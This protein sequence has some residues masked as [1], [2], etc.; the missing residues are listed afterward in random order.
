MATVSSPEFWNEL[1]AQGGDGWELGEP[2]LPLADF[3]ETTP[4][5]RGRVAVP[6]CGRGHDAR[7]L[8]RR[9]Y[10]VVGFDFADTAITEARTLTR[11]ER[12]DA[13]FEQRDIF[14]LSLDHANTFDGVWEYTCFCAI[15]PRRRE[16]YVRVMAAIL[17]P[18]G[19][20]LGCFYPIR[21]GGG[22]PPFPVSKREVRNL[23][24]P[25]FRIEREFSPIHSV[26]RRQGQEWMVLARKV[27]APR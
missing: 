17:R 27:G 19:W 21:A 25:P 3:I 4:L 11:H 23:F 6:G 7:Y 10:S 18:G 5:P 1:Y 13:A 2:A 16:E 12:V 15:D 24:T 8:A 14:S 20:F 26:R 22:G 9:G